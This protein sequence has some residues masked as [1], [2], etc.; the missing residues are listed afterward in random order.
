Q[1]RLGRTGNLGIDADEDHSDH[2]Q[3]RELH[4]HVPESSLGTREQNGR[5]AGGDRDLPVHLL[6]VEHDTVGQG[7]CPDGKNWTCGGSHHTLALLALPLYRRYDEGFFVGP[8]Y[9]MSAYL[10]FLPVPG[11]W[12]TFP[13]PT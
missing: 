11:A 6:V 10:T 1:G 13:A 3:V 7:D 2:G 9:S 8:A 5:D 12:M 4:G